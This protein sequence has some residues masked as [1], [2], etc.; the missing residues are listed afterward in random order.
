MVHEATFLHG[1]VEDE[2]ADVQKCKEGQKA[3]KVEQVSRSTAKREA[4]APWDAHS[5]VARGSKGGV[6][7]LV[8]CH[9]V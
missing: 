2:V 5:K 6:A 9:A 8:L 3:K 7:C 1:Q 4:Q